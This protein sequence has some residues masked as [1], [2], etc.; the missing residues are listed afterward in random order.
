[1]LVRRLRRGARGERDG[2]S[3]PSERSLRRRRRSRR[4]RLVFAVAVVGFGRRPDHRRC[5]A[6]ISS[7]SARPAPSIA[8]SSDETGA[9][10]V[11]PALESARI[12]FLR[13][14]PVARAGALRAESRSSTS[15]WCS[16]GRRGVRALPDRPRASAASARRPSA[17]RREPRYLRCAAPRC[18]LCC[19][20]ALAGLAGAAL[21]ARDGTHVRRGHHRGTRLHRARGRRV[22]TLV[23]AG[24]RSRARCSSGSRARCSSSSRRPIW[25]CPYQLFLMLP[26]VVTLAVLALSSGAARAPQALGTPYDRGLIGRIGGRLG[27]PAAARALQKVPF[28]RYQTN[29]PAAAYI[30]YALDQPSPPPRTSTVTTRMVETTATTFSMRVSR[31]R[32]AATK[33]RDLRAAVRTAPTWLADELLRRSPGKADRCGPASASVRELRR[34]LRGMQPAAAAIGRSY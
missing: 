26:Y 25:A 12:P 31:S 3:P 11:L 2:K 30:G 4:G 5:G 7:R 18:A 10:L 32:S 24:A 29:T 23:A 13:D 27:G 19:R 17:R 21:V 8:R 9:A 1:M 28:A 20:R 15:R 6:S 14:L 22:R 16:A 34:T 33:R